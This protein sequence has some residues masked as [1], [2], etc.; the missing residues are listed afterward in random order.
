MQTFALLSIDVSPDG[1]LEEGWGD[2][3]SFENPMSSEILIRSLNNFHYRIC[4]FT[5]PLDAFFILSTVRPN[6]GNGR[7]FCL[8]I[9]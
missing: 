7:I 1:T 9:S 8:E 5:Y 6:L 2:G 3:I 4:V